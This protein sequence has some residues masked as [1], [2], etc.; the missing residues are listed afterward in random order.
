MV[1]TYGA[2][3]FT[4]PLLVAWMRLPVTEIVPRLGFFTGFEPIVTVPPVVVLTGRPLRVAVGVIPL[5][6]TI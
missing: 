4:V 3:M 5:F 2:V 1:I 6:T